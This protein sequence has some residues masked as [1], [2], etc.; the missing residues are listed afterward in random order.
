MPEF[1]TCPDC[2]IKLQVAAT[3]APG[4]KLRCPK[5]KGTFI[6]TPLEEDE[7]REEED[8]PVAKS[9]PRRASDD[10]YEEDDRPIK[11]RGR[12]SR[13]FEFDGSAGDYFVVA[14]ITGLLSTI[15]LGLAT[16]WTMCMM[17]KWQA[18]HTLINGRR[19]RFEGTGGGCL[20]LFI[21]SYLLIFVTLGIYT[22]WAVPKITRWFT[23]HLEFEEAD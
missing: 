1:V 18:E 2:G 12:A 14:L 8:R 16:P 17:V 4:K 3:A 11:K 19:L 5:C 15:T 9:S 21:V 22:F 6:P 20:V 10:D 23:E 13:T 7:E